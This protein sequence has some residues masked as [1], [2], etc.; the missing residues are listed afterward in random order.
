MS[1][2]AAVSVGNGA[3]NSTVVSCARAEGRTQTCLNEERL[4]VARVE[5]DQPRAGVNGQDV[6]TSELRELFHTNAVVILK[7]GSS[8]H[9]SK[10]II[11]HIDTDVL[12]CDLGSALVVDQHLVV[13]HAVLVGTRV[14]VQQRK[15]AASD[16]GN[17][18]GRILL[19]DAFRDKVVDRLVILNL[20]H[21]KNF[22]S[23]GVRVGLEHLE[24]GSLRN[25]KDHAQAA[26][27]RAVLGQGLN[28]EEK[29]RVLLV[30]L[31]CRIDDKHGRTVVLGQVGFANFQ[32]LALKPAPPTVAGVF[33]SRVGVARY[34][35]PS[36]TKQIERLAVVD[37]LRQLTDKKLAAALG[38]IM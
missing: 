17:R 4:D 29:F 32:Q 7:Q 6:L 38:A 5:R 31:V 12:Q 9:S 28:V 2:V 18:V 10:H 35:S 25:D 27:V 16:S 13:C 20:A 24:G 36:A 34:K 8:G 19:V 33:L 1:N 30:N 11:S 15:P 21:Q 22:A 23:R 14:A 37:G 3:Q 26:R